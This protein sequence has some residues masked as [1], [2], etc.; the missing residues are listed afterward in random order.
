MVFVNTEPDP[1]SSPSY[2][3]PSGEIIYYELPQQAAI[4]EDDGT[5]KLIIRVM[6]LNEEGEMIEDLVQEMGVQEKG[7][8]MTGVQKIVNGQPIFIDEVGN[9]SDANESGEITVIP[10]ARPAEQLDIYSFDKQ[11]NQLVLKQVIFL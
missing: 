2:Q 4:L 1:N 8:Q 9:E 10:A 7:V 11:I 3:D 6:V 5:G